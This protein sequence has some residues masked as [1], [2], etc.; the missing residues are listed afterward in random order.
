MRKGAGACAEQ[1][2]GGT[3]FE[4]VLGHIVGSPGPWHVAGQGLAL[5]VRQAQRCVQVAMDDEICEDAGAAPMA[6]SPFPHLCRGRLPY[7]GSPNAPE[8]IEID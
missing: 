6:C 4:G 7:A 3:N 1:Q 8:V 5:G 2:V